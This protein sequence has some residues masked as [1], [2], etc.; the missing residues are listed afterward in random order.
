M[1]IFHFIG[2]QGGEQRQKLRVMSTIE[3]I[4]QFIKLFGEKAGK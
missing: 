4:E 3:E 2:I 1:N